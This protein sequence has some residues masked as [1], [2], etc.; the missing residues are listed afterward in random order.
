MGHGP[1]FRDIWQKW[2][3]INTLFAIKTTQR[4]VN[5]T[6]LLNSNAT[7]TIPMG[8]LHTVTQQLCESFCK[9]A[10]WSYY[11]RGVI[12]LSA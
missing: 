11:L 6:L 2:T 1:N 8:F 5:K 9:A 7:D 4:C 12:I 10:Q 3:I